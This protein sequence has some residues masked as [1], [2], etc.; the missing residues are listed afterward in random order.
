VP[1]K[2]EVDMRILFKLAALSLLMST[3][4]FAKQKKELPSIRKVV[5]LSDLTIDQ[6]QEIFTGQ[7]P[8]V[9]ILCEEGFEFPLKYI[10]RF[11]FATASLAPNL[12]IKIEQNC[13]FRACGK[14]VYMSYDLMEWTKPEYPM[15]RSKVSAGFNS[16]K[17]EFLVQ[18]DPE[19]TIDEEWEDSED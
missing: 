12:K 10:A 2:N 8:D 14:K 15:R 5:N 18:V 7:L 6:T 9:A 13:Y 19:M 16:S 1:F 4:V 17:S 11:G 3:P